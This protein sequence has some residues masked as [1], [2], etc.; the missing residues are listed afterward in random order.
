MPLTVDDPRYG[1][2]FAIDQMLA[3]RGGGAI[4]TDATTRGGPE[5]APSFCAVKAC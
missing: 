2:D 5:P 1:Y 3:E 4:H